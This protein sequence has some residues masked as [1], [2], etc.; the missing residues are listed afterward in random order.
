MVVAQGAVPKGVPVPHTS[1]SGHVI[2]LRRHASA[3]TPTLGQSAH[4]L[5]PVF[6]FLKYQ[7]VNLGFLYTSTE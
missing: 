2:P 5:F 7:M 3:R 4:G 1:S 6:A